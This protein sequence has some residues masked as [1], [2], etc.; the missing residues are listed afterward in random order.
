MKTSDSVWHKQL[1]ELPSESQNNPYWLVPFQN[2]KT[3]CPYLVGGYTR[4]AQELARYITAG[5][6]TFI[7][8]IPPDEEELRH[9]NVAFSQALQQV[10]S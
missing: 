4:V 7:L 1:S 6:Q 9:T 8:D 10:T 5:Y 3:F 2:Y